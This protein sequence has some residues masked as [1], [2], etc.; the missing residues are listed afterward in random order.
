MVAHDRPAEATEDRQSPTAAY[1]RLGARLRP[2]GQTPEP[3]R[4]VDDARRRPPIKDACIRTF[5][6]RS[7]QAW[8]PQITIYPDW[9]DRYTTMATSLGMP[10]TDINEAVDVVHGL[11]HRIDVAGLR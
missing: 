11:I 6:A 5:A 3:P 2:A 4:S 1:H 8:P 7:Q 9:P 10:I